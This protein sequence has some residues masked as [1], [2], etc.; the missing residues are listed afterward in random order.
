MMTAPRLFLP[1]RA[2]I[3]A[4]W[5][6]SSDLDRLVVVFPGWGTG[7]KAAYHL[8]VN[9]ETRQI[10]CECLGFRYRGYCH[11]SRGLIWCTSKPAKSKGAAETSIESYRKFTEEDLSG[12]QRAV[13]DCLQEYGPMSNKQIAA[14]MGWPINTITPRVL[15][16][17]DGL[18]MVAAYGEQYD[19]KTQ[20]RETVWTALNGGGA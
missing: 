1:S 19:E 5:V 20:R 2:N 13:Y 8:T 11:H 18:G 16:L 14:K 12:R 4:Q 6:V 3:P 7:D 17:R 9:V 15:E 10:T